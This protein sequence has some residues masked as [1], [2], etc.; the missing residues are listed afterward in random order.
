MHKKPDFNIIDVKVC[1]SCNM[2]CEYCYQIYNGERT[3]PIMS[4]ENANNLIKFSERLKEEVGWF[5]FTLAGGEP[6]TY[7]HLEHLATGLSKAGHRVSTITNFTCDIDKIRQYILGIGENV[8]CFAISVHLSQWDNIEDFYKKLKTLIDMNS[9]VYIQLTC[10]ITEENYL[11]AFA[12]EDR[13]KNE[14]GLEIQLQRYYGLGYRYK[15]YSDEVEKALLA[16]NLNVP[17]EEANQ[18]FFNGRLCWNGIRFFYI[19]S[20][21]NV[22]RCYAPQTDNSKFILGNLSNWQDITIFKEP[23][24]CL[25]KNECLSY[26]FFEGKGFVIQS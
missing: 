20:D 19:E 16:R 6:F 1:Y 22:Q 11:K 10:V 13:I 4:L 14:F 23:Q 25:T 8:G 2:A 21:G 18:A 9:G 24:P 26:K 15:I 17:Q 5:Y 7:P 12:L 3:K